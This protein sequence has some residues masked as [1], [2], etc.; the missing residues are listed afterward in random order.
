MCGIAGYIDFTKKAGEEQLRNMTD[1]LSHRGPDA[2]GYALFQES[3]CSIGLGHR[4]LSIIDL[5][6]LGQQPMYTA[7]RKT[8]IVFNGEIFNYTEIREELRTKGYSFISNS[9]TEVILYAYREWGPSAVNRFIGMFAMIIYDM[10]KEEVFVCVDRAGVKPFYYYWHN[11]VFL[12]ASELKSFFQFPGYEKIIDE[13]SFYNFLQYSFVPAPYSIF[14]N[15]WKLEP[16][17]YLRI[18]LKSRKIEKQQYWNVLDYYNKPKLNISEE[19]ALTEME[20]R[21][22]KACEYRMVSD[23]P[24]GLFLSGG[25]DSSLVAAMLQT[26]RTNK[27]KTFTIGFPEK[28]Y[29]EASYAKQ[30]AA[31]LGTEHHEMYCTYE[32]AKSIIPELPYYYDEPFGDS[33]AIPTILVSRFARKSVTVALSADGGDELF[34]GYERHVALMGV[35]RR[36][37]SIPG[38]LRKPGA[39]AIKNAPQFILDKITKGKNTSKENIRKYADFISGKSG[40]TDMADYANQ[41]AMPEFLSS[42]LSKTRTGHSPLFQKESVRA[43]KGKLDQLLA[44]DYLSYLPGD[45]LTKVDRATMSVSLEGREPLLDQNIIEWVATLPDIYKY[46]GGDTKYLLRKIVH[47]HIPKE[48]MHRPKMGFAIPLKEWFRQDLKH[49]FDENLSESAINKHGLINYS[50]L[51]EELNSYYKGNNF[52]FPLLWSILMFQLWYDKWM[53]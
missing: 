30:V 42:F 45:I 2:S 18:D 14:T 43:L 26:G 40:I 13:R 48:I 1:C 6:P 20:R 10:L 50:R 23:V 38:V 27:I 8:A 41:T 52:Q 47:K 16:G 24:V 51:K 44:F 21:L 32:E 19:D 15:T 37:E 12:F 3:T 36:M 11:N 17:H 5:S 28:E 22:K 39:V 31:H 33:S 35:Q 4:R 9:D 46:S 34:A 7:D 53:K 49:L 25:Y 29:D